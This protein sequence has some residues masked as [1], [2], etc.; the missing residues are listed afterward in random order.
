MSRTGYFREQIETMPRD[1]LDAVID[2]RVRY[3]I[4]YAVDHSPFYRKWFREHGI[5]TSS[6]RE[7]EDLLGLPI[8]SGTTI[9]NNQPPI[10]N[11]FQFLSSRMDE[12]YTI[13][14]T[15]GTSGVPK[16]FFLTWQDWLRYSEKYARIFRSYGI[17]RGD[18]IVVCASYGMNVGATMMTLA[19]R[20]T[21]STIIP[22]GKCTFPL[23]VIKNY[24][25]TVV[26]G[27]VFKLIRLA[28]RLEAEGIDPQKTSIERL[29][30]G[31]ES[32]AE[33]SRKYLSRLW[34]CE[35]YNTYGSTEGTMC[36]ECYAKAGLHVPEDLI[37]MD[38]YNPRMDHFVRDG[39]YGRIILTKLLPVGER[40][41][42]LLINYDTED[43]T[44][45]VSRDR[46]ACG[47]TSLRIKTPERE[48]ER[49][50]VEDRSFNRVDIE[51][52]VFQEE[53][54]DYLTGEYEAFLYG[55]RETE[56]TILRVSL[57]C[58][59]PSSVDAESIQEIFRK[60]FF[61][62]KPELREPYISGT[63][64][65]LFHFTGPGELELYKV[66]GRPKRVVDRR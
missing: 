65:I 25:P 47:R 13:H 34:G 33:A 51:R 10:T 16:S 50:F 54:M 62:L 61:R 60:A 3:T 46:C 23:R 1:D 30:V 15:S 24:R 42:T 6:I 27:S 39:E 43:A 22:E 11:D 31:G 19:A 53:N 63:L 52:G 57:E 9:R 56:S 41:G 5:D 32:F 66:Q 40:C 55:G 20:R 18:R 48:G 45:V 64:E 2:E 59:D 4:Q 37:H 35:V 49:F 8:I 14:E 58:K 7:H 17:S 38:L 44:A 26:I 28:R 21:G 36:G 29:V 12:I